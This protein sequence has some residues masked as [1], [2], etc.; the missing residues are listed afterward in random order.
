MLYIIALRV[1]PFQINNYSH[2]VFGTLV[3]SARKYYTNT[4]HI[5]YI[6][7]TNTT[8]PLYKRKRH[9][10]DQRTIAAVVVVATV[11]LFVDVAV[12]AVVVVAGYAVSSD[13][14]IFKEF[15]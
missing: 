12:A 15:Q 14:L 2:Y 11:V 4:I 10:N 5:F 9:E 1:L 13:T 7:Y 8:L 3:V 6:Y